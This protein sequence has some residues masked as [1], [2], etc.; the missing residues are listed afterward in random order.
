MVV[1]KAISPFISTLLCFPQQTYI[2]SICFNKV[3]FKKKIMQNLDLPQRTVEVLN[4]C[5]W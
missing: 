5:K 2:Y 1:F 3:K 4:K